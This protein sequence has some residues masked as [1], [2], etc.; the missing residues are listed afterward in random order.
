MDEPPL[1]SW[2]PLEHSSCYA[3]V[4]FEFDYPDV[5]QWSIFI[6]SRHEDDSERMVTEYRWTPEGL[7][8]EDLEAVRLVTIPDSDHAIFI[9]FKLD[10]CVASP[11]E[12][13][14]LAKEISVATP[15]SQ[16]PEWRDAIASK[17]GTF[18]FI[19]RLKDSGY[20]QREESA[21]VITSTL[22]SLAKK[23]VYKVL[24]KEQIKTVLMTV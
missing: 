2:I 17:E 7:D 24:A 15:F 22:D 14:R 5:W 21:D 11:E 3:A 18:T 10:G 12:V 13:D 9:C 6:T 1:Y 23:M 4:T 8:I 19:T 20:L 16:Y